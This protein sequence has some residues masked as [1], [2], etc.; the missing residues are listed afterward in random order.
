M[1]CISATVPPGTP[2]RV[3]SS[4]SWSDSLNCLFLRGPQ[5]VTCATRVPVFEHFFAPFFQTCFFTTTGAKRC[6]TGSLKRA[7]NRTNLE[8]W[9]PAQ[10]FKKKDGKSCEKVHF[11]ESW[12]CN[13]HTPVQSKHTFLC[14]SFG[15]KNDQKSLPKAPQNRPKIIKKRLSSLSRIHA[16]KAETQNAKNAKQIWTSAL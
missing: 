6:Q 5:P 11:P 9:P 1:L 12:I 7:Q 14:S 2:G 4:V 8:K 10:G 3:R 15:R 13:P 16:E